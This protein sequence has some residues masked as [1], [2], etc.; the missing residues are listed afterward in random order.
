[1]NRRRVRDRRRLD[2]GPSSRFALYAFDVIVS[3]DV[4]LMHS[5]ANSG[6]SWSTSPHIVSRIEPA[7]PAFIDHWELGQRDRRDD[8]PTLMATVGGRSR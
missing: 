2:P 4:P 7:P 8:G 6:P 3:V 1:M 5:A